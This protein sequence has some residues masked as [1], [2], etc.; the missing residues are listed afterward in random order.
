MSIGIKALIASALVMKSPSAVVK[1]DLDMAKRKID[2]E[3]A[4]NAKQL[5]CSA[6][7]VN[8]QCIYAKGFCRVVIKRR[9]YPGRALCRSFR[10]DHSCR[11]INLVGK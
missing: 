8:G 4:S 6:C 5:P 3:V 9:N 2:F 11:R 10:T 7:G 1:V